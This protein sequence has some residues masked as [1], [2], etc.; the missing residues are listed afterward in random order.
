MLLNAC[1]Q[2]HREQ[3]VTAELE[4]IVAITT[5]LNPEKLPPDTGNRIG[6]GI[7]GDIAGSR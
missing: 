5:G 3:G 7:G 2:L 1:V 4:E 6:G